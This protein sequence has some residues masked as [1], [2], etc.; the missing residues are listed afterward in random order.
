MAM[1]KAQ[2]V[3]FMEVIR[4]QLEAAERVRRAQQQAAEKERNFLLRQICELMEELVK[5]KK[6]STLDFNTSSEAKFKVWK[7]T[8]DNYA[9]MNQINLEDAQSQS[10]KKLGRIKKVN[11]VGNNYPATTVHITHPVTNKSLVWHKAIAYTGAEECVAGVNFLRELGLGKK[12][13]EPAHH[14]MIAFNGSSEPCLGVLKVKVTN[15]HYQMDAEVNI[16][17]NVTEN[18]LLSLEACKKLG[19]V[20]EEFPRVISPK[21]RHEFVRI[22]SDQS[23]KATQDGKSANTATPSAQSNKSE[24]GGTS[25]QHNTRS[26]RVIVINRVQCVGKEP[27]VTCSTRKQG[28]HTGAP[29]SGHHGEH[30]QVLTPALHQGQ[31]VGVWDKVSKRWSL[32]ATVVRSDIKQRNY[33]LQ[34][35]H[36]YF[37]RHHNLVRPNPGVRDEP[38]PEPSTKLSSLMQ[39]TQRR[40]RTGDRARSSSAQ[41]RGDSSTSSASPACRKHQKRHRPD[42]V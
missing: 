3:T 20:H 14:E 37:W 41:Q 12:D 7:T 6:E 24:P 40:R 10:S 8:W 1:I 28:H 25:S 19:Y 34:M 9:K 38:T 30:K 23:N 18:L 27:D 32:E 26:R 16:C 4:S 42:Q 2:Q 13:L 21:Q 22:M 39:S 17:P 36:H 5:V 33:L 29:K 15:Q 11:H 31:K 35:D